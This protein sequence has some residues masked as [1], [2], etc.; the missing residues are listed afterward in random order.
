MQQ[1]RSDG[2][3]KTELLSHKI[4]RVN[5]FFVEDSAYFAYA[6]KIQM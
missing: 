3:C 4:L 1:V 2:Y 6:N 5:H